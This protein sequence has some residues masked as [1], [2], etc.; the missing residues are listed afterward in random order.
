MGVRWFGGTLT[1]PLPFDAKREGEGRVGG[2]VVKSGLVRVN[3]GPR[4]PAPPSQ[5]RTNPKDAFTSLWPS[6]IPGMR[7]FDVIVP[8]GGELE[9]S[10]ASVVGTKSKA[11]VRFEGVTVLH[12]ILQALKESG[13]VGRIAVIGPQAVITHEDCRCDFHLPER[14][15]G[16]KNIT[17]GLAALCEGGDPERVLICTSDLVFLTPDAIRG[18]VER[19]GDKDFYAPLI[20]REEWEDAYPMSSATFVKLKEGDFTLGC[21]YSVRVTALKRALTHIEAVFARRKSKLGMANMLGWKYVFKYLLRRLSLVELLSRVEEIL[22]CT[23]EPIAGSAPEFAFDIDAID[24][25]H[26]ALQNY[27]A[28]LKGKWMPPPPR[29]A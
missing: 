29:Q 23:V 16:P 1:E 14:E 12:R 21:L 17:S 22:G 2:S 20:T 7:Q 10:F 8:A 13:V 15:S 27:K 18:F 6:V 24:D 3:H 9:A 4:F 26:Y 25:Y 5:T 28:S 19:C 11:L